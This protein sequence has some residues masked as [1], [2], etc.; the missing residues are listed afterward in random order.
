MLRRATFHEWFVDTGMLRAALRGG[1]LPVGSSVADLGSGTG[2]YARW[3]NDTGLVDAF[4]YDGSADI[5]LLT[6]KKVTH[7]NL[8]TTIRRPPKHNWVLLIEICEHIPAELHP[9][10]F[11]NVNSFAEDGIIL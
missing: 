9:I 10:F 11:Q 4:S 6:K 2:E 8:V 3:L 1:V 7:L 5:E